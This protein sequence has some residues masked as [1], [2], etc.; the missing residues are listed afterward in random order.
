MFKLDAD[1]LSTF[2][3][4]ASLFIILN[5]N[6]YFLVPNF[7]AIRYAFNVSDMYLGL[8]SGGYLFANG[9]S[10]IA[11]A[12]LSETQMKT[13]KKVLSLSFILAS[14]FMFFE[15]FVYSATY[16]IIIIILTGVS[17]GSVLPLGFSIIA[18][19]FRSEER[20]QA[21][22]LWY[23][24]GGFGISLGIAVSSIISSIFSWRYTILLDSILLLIGGVLSYFIKEPM[25]G[26][27][28]IRSY[29]K[30]ELLTFDSNLR[31]KDL[32]KI[33]TNRTNLKLILESTFQVIP[34]AVI[35]IWGFQFI[36]RELKVC[37]VAALVYLSIVGTGAFGGIILA[38]I[39]DKIYL[40]NKK[41]RP[42]MGSL[43][44]L[45]SALFLILFSSSKFEL[46]IYNGDIIAVFFE[47][48][49]IIISNPCIFVASIFYF[50]GKLVN[51]PL[52]PIKE[53]VLADINLP[54]H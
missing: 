36:M 15:V 50:I 46:N 47:I 54:E 32:R 30:V 25:R 18:D 1:H 39:I 38:R 49:E 13:R 41:M 4:L 53:S 27:S 6:T 45:L 12:Y 40:K 22:T 16:F 3:Q 44:C 5:Y 33:I 42:I 34:D 7:E 21:Y 37:N 52:G 20:T 10:T 17:L 19:I 51:T 26:W 28:D 2:V 31:L 24:I 48:L 8:L 9:F 43:F 23:T 14:L 29:G 35:L 11:W